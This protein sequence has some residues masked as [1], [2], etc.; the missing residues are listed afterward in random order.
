MADLERLATKATRLERLVLGQA[1]GPLGQPGLEILSKGSFQLT[2]LLMPRHEL[3]GP[4]AGKTLA[5]GPAFEN[6]EYL[7]LGDNPLTDAFFKNFVGRTYA[8]LQFLGLQ[9]VK[10]GLPGF[11]LLAAA[12][13]FPALESLNLEADGARKLGADGAKL[14]TSGSFLALR[15]LKMK[16]LGLDD[17]AVAGLL[18]ASGLPKLEELHLSGQGNLDLPALIP[19]LPETLSMPLRKLDFPGWTAADLPWERLSW[20]RDLTVLRLRGTLSG[21]G[22]ESF[23]KR[24]PLASLSALDLGQCKLTPAA[25]ALLSKIPFER[26]KELG[27][28]RT[29]L[30]PD[31]VGPLLEAPW[32]DRVATLQVQAAEVGEAAV[33][34]LTKRTQVAEHLDILEGS[35]P[36]FRINAFDETGHRLVP[37]WTRAT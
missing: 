18:G 13:S 37:P 34:A 24:A 23:L 7:D 22:A 21:A 19:R 25:I 11:A 17:D 27:L 36:A 9:N 3:K 20:L 15:R 8:K 16:C 10:M 6:L 35:W 12:S 4:K 5:T 29:Q 14:A 33:A 26:L 32:L 28:S 30:F 2:H 31:V 1:G